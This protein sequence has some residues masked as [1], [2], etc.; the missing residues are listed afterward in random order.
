MLPPMRIGE[1]NELGR[2]RLLLQRQLGELGAAEFASHVAVNPDTGRLRILVATDTGLLDYSYSPVGQTDA[3]WILRGLLMRWQAVRG[4]RLQT[5]AQIVEET[6][7]VRSVWRLVAEE[8]K[9]ELV[10]NSED[11]DDRAV[12][13]LL[14]FARACLQHAG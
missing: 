3:D 12:Q 2:S 4:L 14:A 5:D 7:A 8:P 9:I 13:A 1:W 11:E 10:A 6:Q